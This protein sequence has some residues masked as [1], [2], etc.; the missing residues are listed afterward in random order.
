[1]ADVLIAGGGI[2][3]SSLA[4][5]LGRAG[6]SVELFEQGQF[7]REKACGEGIMPAG[8]AVLERLGLADMVGGA[9]FYGV[10]YFA[11]DVV[12][13]GR[14][15]PLNGRPA[16][17]RGQRRWRLDQV[18]FTAAAATPGV[19]AHT[20]AHVDAPIVEHGRVVGLRVVGEERYAPLTVAADGA[21]SRVRRLLGL[22]GPGSNRKRVGL[23]THFR[24]APGKMQPPWVEV[25]LERDAELYVTPLPNHEIL[26]AA[27]MPHQVLSNGSDGAFQRLIEVQ[28][29]LRAR[30]AG[31]EQITAFKG[32]SP[33]TTNARARVLPGAL[34]LGDAAG[35]VDPI[36]GGG[37]TQALLTAELL[38]E[39]LHRDGLDNLAWL[40]A[41]DRARTALL[42]DYRWLTQIVLGLASRPALTRAALRLLQCT[43]RVFSHLLG[44]ATGMH[45]LWPLPLTSARVHDAV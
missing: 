2:A 28:P 7:P 19:A 32:M 4:I 43:P 18:L 26:A 1:M 14:F 39:Y 9:P 40:A 45:H 22:D 35:F 33:L 11:G 10:R 16:A 27:L 25:F 30:L 3:G 12:A 36:T 17:G 15:P 42:Q 5:M 20:N 34:L 24:L 6:L 37:I 13:E 38:A 8:V 44:A 23:R 31:A 29:M 21:H 41:Y